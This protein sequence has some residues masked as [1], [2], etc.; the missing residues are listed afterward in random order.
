MLLHAGVNVVVLVNGVV[1]VHAV[2]E[3]HEITAVC[4]VAVFTMLHE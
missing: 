4:V 1:E 2:T 3:G